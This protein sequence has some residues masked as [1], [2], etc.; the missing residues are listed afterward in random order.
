MNVELQ[1]ALQQAIQDRL[2]L[3]PIIARFTAPINLQG[4]DLRSGD[5]RRANLQ[6]AHFRYAFLRGVDFR[7]ADLQYADFRDAFLW[8]ADF[9]GANLRG[10]Y[11]QGA[12]LGEVDLRE[13]DLRETDLSGVNLHEV[14]LGDMVIPVVSGLHTLILASLAAGGELD[15]GTYHQCATS[16][17]HAGWVIHHAGAA[18]K[19]LEVRLGSSAVAALI[20]VASC[21][22][23]EGQVPNFHDS[24]DNALA[25]I[26]NFAELEQK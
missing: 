1:Q 14:K 10:S 24:D 20:L 21:P 22:Y 18:G 8:L 2:P 3:A 12:Y 25:T 5:L 7:G 9:R 16:H 13:V 15:M 17:C 26:K 23:L 19:D 4:A 6:S 11:F